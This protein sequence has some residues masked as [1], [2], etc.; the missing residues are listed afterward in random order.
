MATKKA[1]AVFHRSC[2]DF[3]TGQLLRLKSG[4][5]IQS[6]ICYAPHLLDA[7]ATK[8]NRP[9][10]DGSMENPYPPLEIVN[11]FFKSSIL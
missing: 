1:D 6:M 7:E 9:Y 10:I 5:V 4:K 8:L 3:S 11:G 2:Q